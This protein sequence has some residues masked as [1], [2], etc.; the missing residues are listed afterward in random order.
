MPL[1]VHAV[2][3]AYEDNAVLVAILRKMIPDLQHQTGDLKPSLINVVYG[4]QA[5][6]AA[7][8][9]SRLPVEANGHNA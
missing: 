3:R 2:E 9:T 7:A 1:L 6:P 8:P 5:P 4:H